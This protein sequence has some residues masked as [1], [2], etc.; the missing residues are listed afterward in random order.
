[1]G[2]KLVFMKNNILVALFLIFLPVAFLQFY[3]PTIS[4]GGD[5]QLFLDLFL[6]YL[7]YLS[8]G[9]ERYQVVAMGFFIGLFQDFIGQSSLLGVFAF[10]KTIA[11]YFLCHLFKYDRVWNYGVKLLYLFLVFKIHY[12]LATYL[13][14]DRSF[15]PFSYIF[16]ISFIQTVFMIALTMVVNKFILVDKKI[17]K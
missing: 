4:F 6:I 11:A 1:M 8:I 10:T 16:K 2:N 15:T 12:I 14:F 7:A 3:I 5:V 13:M 9:Q 17:I